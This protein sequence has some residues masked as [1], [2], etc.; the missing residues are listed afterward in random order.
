MKLVGFVLSTVL[1]IYAQP[2][3]AIADTE[4]LP[5]PPPV[6]CM[7]VHPEI[8]SIQI[9]TCQHKHLLRR[10]FRGVKTQWENYWEAL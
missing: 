10:L 9:R 4:P 6:C 5:I 8:R 3:F 2:S 1:T 7:T